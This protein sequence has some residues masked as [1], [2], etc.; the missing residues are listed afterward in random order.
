M[1]TEHKK[2]QKN[3]EKNERQNCMCCSEYRD[4]YDCDFYG[5]LSPVIVDI[6]ISYLPE[7]RNIYEIFDNLDKDDIICKDCAEHIIPILN[8]SDPDPNNLC[9]CVYN[10]TECM[11]TLEDCM[12][13]N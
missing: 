10:Y 5:K 11:I 3:I 1:F 8:E 2:I 7:Y 9:Q 4:C 6:I 13:C 12:Y